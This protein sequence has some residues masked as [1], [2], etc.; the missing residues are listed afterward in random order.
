[1]R[2]ELGRAHEVLA[3]RPGVGELHERAG[4][5]VRLAAVGQLDAAHRL[6]H[7]LVPEGAVAGQQHLVAEGEEVGGQVGGRGD[8]RLG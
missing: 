5:R 7:R 6:E 1:M 2:R 4:E 3:Q 8:L